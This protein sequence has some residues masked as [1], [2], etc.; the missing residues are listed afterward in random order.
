MT[1]TLDFLAEHVDR[2]LN[3]MAQMRDDMRVVAAVVMRLD[4]TVQALVSKVRAEHARFD[5]FVARVGK[6][7]EDSSK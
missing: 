2:V 3:E 6:L 5:R 4:G 7:E 1:V